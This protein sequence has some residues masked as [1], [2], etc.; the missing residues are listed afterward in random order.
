MQ[1]EVNAAILKESKTS[2]ESVC[3]SNRLEP[4]SVVSDIL[5]SVSKCGLI[6]IDEVSPTV[7][8]AQ[9]QHRN[10]P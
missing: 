6:E 4:S 7:A 8:A 5:D 9:K 1:E 2:A 10:A 3:I